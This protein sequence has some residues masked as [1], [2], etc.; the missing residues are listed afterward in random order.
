VL[1]DYVRTARSLND[2]VDVVS[3][4]HEYGIWGGDEGEHVHDFARGDRGPA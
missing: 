4:Q 1:S 3:I 2:C